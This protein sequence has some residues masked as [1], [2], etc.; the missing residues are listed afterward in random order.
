MGGSNITI[1][2]K[3]YLGL[4]FCLCQDSLTELHAIYTNNV[5]KIILD[6]G[7]YADESDPYVSKPNLYGGKKKGGGV[8]GQLRLQFGD[9]TQTS[10]AYLNNVI[11]IDP[12]LPVDLGVVP[13]RGLS[14]ITAEQP[15]ICSMNPSMR[16]WEFKG[17]RRPTLTYATNATTDIEVLTSGMV[18]AEDGYDSNPAAILEECFFNTEW[19]LGLTDEDV[20]VTSIESAMTTL[21]AEGV[22]LS[23]RLA[24]QTTMRNF[25]R[26]ILSHINGVLYQDPSTGKIGV[27]LL[28][29]SDTS[30]LTIDDTNRISFDSFE[31]TS[32]TA[33]VNEIVVEYTSKDN[34]DKASLA[35]HSSSNLDIQDNLITRTMSYKG[36]RSQALASRIG[37]RDL[38]LLS[39]PLARIG[40]TVNK[41]GWDLKVGEVIQV[42]YED[43]DL[44]DTRFRIINI[45]YGSI[46]EGAI[47]ITAM[48]DVLQDYS[49]S[50]TVYGFNTDPNEST[51]I[52]IATTV[53][54]AS[55][56]YMSLPVPYYAVYN[57]Q[58]EADFAYYDLS[59]DN[60]Y[61]LSEK[62]TGD[63]NGFILDDNAGEESPMLEPSY[64]LEITS[65]SYIG[66]RRVGTAFNITATFLSQYPISAEEQAVI[67]ASTEA[68][69][70][71]DDEIFLVDNISGTE[72]YT[73]QV[74]RG[75]FDSVPTYH[76]STLAG[77]LVAYLLID[78][79]NRSKMYGGLDNI[80]IADGSTQNY[81]LKTETFSD[82]LSYA[83]S[84]AI[85]LVGKSRADRPDPPKDIQVSYNATQMTVSWNYN[86]KTTAIGTPAHEGS[87]TDSPESTDIRTTV[88]VR[89]ADGTVLLNANYDSTITSTSITKVAEEALTIDG[90]VSPSVFIEVWCYYNSD[91]TNESLYRTKIQ[92]FRQEV[93]MN[94]GFD[95]YIAQ[96]ASNA[97]AFTNTGNT[98]ARQYRYVC[99]D[100]SFVLVTGAAASAVGTVYLCSED[101][102]V[103]TTVS[104]GNCNTMM[105]GNPDHI[106]VYGASSAAATIVW[107]ANGTNFNVAAA[108][109][110]DTTITNTFTISN[111]DFT[112]ASQVLIDSSYAYITDHSQQVSGGSTIT[113]AIHRVDHDGTNQTLIQP[114]LDTV[115]TQAAPSP[116]FAETIQ[117]TATA[118]TLIVK[119]DNAYKVAFTTVDWIERLVAST[120][121]LTDLDYSA[122]T[123]ASTISDFRSGSGGT[124]FAISNANGDSIGYFT[125]ASSTMSWE[126]AVRDGV[127]DPYTVSGVTTNRNSR[128]CVGGTY[129]YYVE[130][131]GFPDYVVAQNHRPYYSVTGLYED[132][133][134]FLAD[135][136][137]GEESNDGAHWLGRLVRLTTAAGAVNSDG[138]SH[139]NPYFVIAANEDEV[140]GSG[141]AVEVTERLLDLN[142]AETRL[143]VD[144]KYTNRQYWIT[145]P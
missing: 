34:Y 56:N 115:Y 12:S 9:A 84:P 127:L 123:D 22:G 106:D 27:K 16:P 49:A 15:Y 55:T 117:K 130:F 4:Q 62:P 73:I 25:V 119:T 10:L 30:Q 103:N 17:Y 135:V 2:Y 85:S 104:G 8:V 11:D 78:P 98:L 13:L 57:A 131:D 133:Y 93:Y 81:H 88:Y 125:N 32:W 80:A 122:V 143:L 129:V 114:A 37:A 83:S 68:V 134:S 120:S 70:I 82:L 14:T 36:C 99:D 65:G 124:A 42:T 47:K 18:L 28:R 64:A 77:S 35:L 141:F 5:Q 102:T 126:T 92:N 54:V 89:A 19:G 60:F 71:L 140:S 1:G 111:V 20:L 110:M 97:L 61:V 79:V 86:D 44:D 136:S 58:N 107:T 33:T 95:S 29:S 90:L 23:L 51:W 52:P 38:A 100:G 132:D 72:T 45:D 3:Y 69:L 145:V 50:D 74:R 94:D 144:T 41:E 109:T 87:Y 67:N 59:L 96:G 21:K 121:T 63:T 6:A 142:N 40:I 137:T 39:Y 139:D 116:T 76:I 24:E 48:E 7:N 66:D 113:G 91:P 26:E 101:G 128:L 105:D 118:G 112:S 75:A 138:F 53:A 46:F 108:S 31:R 43:Y